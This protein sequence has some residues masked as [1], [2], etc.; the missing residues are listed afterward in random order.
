MM[1]LREDCISVDGE[2]RSR[3]E[4]GE[5][6]CG[7]YFIAKVGRYFRKSDL[8]NEIVTISPCIAKTLPGEWAFE[9]VTMTA[10]EREEAALKDGIA[11]TDV[12]RLIAWTADYLQRNQIRFP[13]L[14]FSKKAAD[15]F[16]EAFAF[17]R[18]GWHLLAIGLRRSQVEDFLVEFESAGRIA[19]EEFGIADAIR[20][21][22]VPDGTGR[23]IGFDVLATGYGERHMVLQFIGGTG[24]DRV[25]HSSRGLWIA[26]HLVPS[27]RVC[28]IR[29]ET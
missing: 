20:R 3:G 6:V 27:R 5:Y 28:G 2:S 21:R 7:G 26:G 24:R 16:L 23:L 25:G 9:Q 15:E 13:D 18:S 1:T 12:G 22:E 8:V 29:G 17:D 10:K 4:F 11:L 19:S 14:F